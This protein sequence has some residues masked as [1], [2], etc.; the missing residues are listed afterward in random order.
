MGDSTTL[1]KLN[2]GDYGLKFEY[3]KVSSF[4]I[5]K[6]LRLIQDQS[7]LYENMSMDKKT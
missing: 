2:S 4:A 7:W 5:V 1:A 6:T 3:F